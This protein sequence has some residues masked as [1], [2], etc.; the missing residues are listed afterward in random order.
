MML[1]NAVLPADSTSAH[2]DL[3]MIVTSVHQSTFA[4]LHAVSTA[5]IMTPESEV[6]GFGNDQPGKESTKL[7][8]STTV[9]ICEIM[10]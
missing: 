6:S 9:S 3:C 7:A 4:P 10:T 5:E 2:A 1:S 8:R